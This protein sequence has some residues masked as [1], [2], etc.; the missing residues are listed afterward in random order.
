M[1]EIYHVW[2]GFCHFGTF[3]MPLKECQ[4]GKKP[5]WK[6]GEQG[7]CYTYKAGDKKSEAIAKLKAAKQ[8]A[9]QQ[10]NK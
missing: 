6:Y 3:D 5:G 10:A 1:V 8:G 7:K 9:A 2:L 4:E